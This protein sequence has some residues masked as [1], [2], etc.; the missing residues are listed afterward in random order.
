M[1]LEEE[2]I[3]FE[4]KSIKYTSGLI[5]VFNKS[6]DSSKV[7]SLIERYY[8]ENIVSNRGFAHP[9]GSDLNYGYKG[10]SSGKFAWDYA[11]LNFDFLTCIDGIFILSN[12]MINSLTLNLYSET[13]MYESEEIIL[14]HSDL[15][16]AIEVAISNGNKFV[17]NGLS[18]IF[19]SFKNKMVDLPEFFSLDLIVSGLMALKQERLSIYYKD[20]EASMMDTESC[21]LNDGFIDVEVSNY[22]INDICDE[23]RKFSINGSPL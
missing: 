15:K 5:V 6:E 3:D 13:S 10:V 12:E 17:E 4:L 14:N 16:D 7:E 1:S 9:Y 23:L 11:R 22:G 2:N 8:P 20:L 21:E 19:Y 18:S